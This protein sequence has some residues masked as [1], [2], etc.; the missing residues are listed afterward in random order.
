M[1]IKH[2]IFEKQPENWDTEIE[3]LFQYFKSSILPTKPI[4]LNK[5]STITNACNFINS[6]LPVI[7]ANNGNRTF[8][9]YLERLQELRRYFESKNAPLTK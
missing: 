9:P 7:E 8:L 4:T 2:P 5:W 1:D 3:N 6:H